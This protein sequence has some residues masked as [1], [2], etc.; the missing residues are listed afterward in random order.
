[1]G[2]R[3]GQRK[4]QRIKATRRAV[5]YSIPVRNTNE[6]SPVNRSCGE[7]IFNQN[8]CIMCLNRCMFIFESHSRA[9]YEFRDFEGAYP[10]CCPE[11]QTSSVLVRKQSAFE[12]NSVRMPNNKSHNCV[13]RIGLTH[14]LISNFTAF[15]Q[16]CP[17]L[18]KSWKTTRAFELGLSFARGVPWMLLCDT[19][20]GH[21]TLQLT[22]TCNSN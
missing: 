18:H 16:F 3:L 14:L 11:I 22:E 5:N 10:Y 9:I 15:A 12:H 21:W 7:Y 6:P 19:K 1:M 8:I 4:W 17:S 20:G 2:L 13:N